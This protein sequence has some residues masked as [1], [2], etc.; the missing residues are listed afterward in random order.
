[1]VWIDRYGAAK[2]LRATS[3]LGIGDEFGRGEQRAESRVQRSK[4]LN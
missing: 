2:K 1:M 3:E 4:Y